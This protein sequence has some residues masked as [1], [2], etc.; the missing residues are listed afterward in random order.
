MAPSRSSTCGAAW[1]GGSRG[2]TDRS[3]R[4]APA[5]RKYP[6]PCYLLVWVRR[7]CGVALRDSQPETKSDER[8][9]SDQVALTAKR[10]GASRTWPG[11][12]NSTNITDPHLRP[13]PGAGGPQALE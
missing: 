7:T 5:T 8:P 3:V 6:E 1:G 9:A 2:R 11:S 13:G 12:G 4:N 10:F